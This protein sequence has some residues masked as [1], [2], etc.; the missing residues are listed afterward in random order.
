VGFELPLPADS[1]FVASLRFTTALHL[2]IDAL[3]DNP[4]SAARAARELNNLLTLA[5]TVGRIA[6]P[7][8]ATPDE[9]ATRQFTDSIVIEPHKDR[10]TLSATI[11]VE[12]LKALSSPNR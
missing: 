4:E 2:R 6:Q 9:R 5:R 12:A 3:A 7:D 1:N 11:P 8:P 10:A